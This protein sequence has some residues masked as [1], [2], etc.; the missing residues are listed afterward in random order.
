V[1]LKPLPRLVTRVLAVMIGVPVGYVVGL[2]LLF[3]SF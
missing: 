2:G 1:G 3:V